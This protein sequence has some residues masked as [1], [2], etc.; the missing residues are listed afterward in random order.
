MNKALLNC[1]RAVGF[2]KTKT[3]KKI[4]IKQKIKRNFTK[5]KNNNNND[6]KKK[7]ECK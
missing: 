6:N 2:C 1:M 7:H 5:K 3:I 4:C